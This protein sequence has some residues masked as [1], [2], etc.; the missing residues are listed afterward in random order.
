MFEHPPLKEAKGM[1]RLLVLDP[2]PAFLG[3]EDGRGNVAVRAALRPLLEVGRAWGFGVVGVTHVNKGGKGPVVY[4]AVGS[5]AY[6]AVARS[7]LLVTEDGREVWDGKRVVASGRRL[8]VPVKNNVGARRAGWAFWIEEAGPGEPGAGG[9]RVVWEAGAVEEARGVGEGR[10]EG[11]GATAG[12]EEAVAYLQ[13]AL[14]DGPRETREVLAGAAEVGI[15]KR[16]LERAR[17]ALGVGGWKEEGTGRWV[18]GV[19]SP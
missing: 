8:V 12:V 7:V 18:M 5:L 13:E 14:K 9:P 2:L 10:L 4:R 1:V 15:S 19:Q 11:W 16:V 17:R 6:T 3:K